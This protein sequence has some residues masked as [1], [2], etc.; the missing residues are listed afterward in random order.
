MSESS[1]PFGFGKL[2]PGFDFLQNLV[3][4]AAKGSGGGS[5][6]GMANWIAPTL[7]VDELDKRIAEL[8]AVSFWLEQNSRALAATIQALEV[9]KMTLSTL[10]GMNMAM[11]DVAQAF[12]IKPQ[13]G[14]GAASAEDKPDPG[15][16]S[17][18]AKAAAE[19]YAKSFQSPAPPRSVPAAEPE[20]ALAP[21]PAAES[22]A[23]PAEHKAAK[24]AAASPGVVDPMQ[25]WTALTG[26]FQQIAAHAMRDAASNPALEATRQAA[27]EAF[28]A[29]GEM[30]AQVAGK[31]AQSV[32]A[33]APAK[34]AARKTPQKAAGKAAAKKTTGQAG[35]K[36]AARKKPSAN[37]P[38]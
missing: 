13:G 7:N 19:I 24:G 2:V 11:T 17:S 6:S 22:A 14:D 35:E 34:K 5:G 20:P 18:A 3:E 1:N 31:A 16:E 38:T 25:W 8:K 33:A 4:S 23:T 36:T 21:A 26:Q 10:S 27:N 12:K 15:A 32:A 29:A 30:T 9:Q 28:K 37:Q